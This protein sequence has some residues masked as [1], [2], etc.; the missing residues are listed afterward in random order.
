MKRKNAYMVINIWRTHLAAINRVFAPIWTTLGMNI[1][2][3]EFLE[4]L[5]RL[6]L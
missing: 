1:S 2:S 4:K 5:F 3:K 6:E